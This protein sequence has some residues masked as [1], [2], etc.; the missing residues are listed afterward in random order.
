M[1]TGKSNLTYPQNISW[2]VACRLAARNIEARRGESAASSAYA[3]THVALLWSCQA[4]NPP[5]RGRARVKPLAK[6]RLATRAA[7][8][9]FGQLQ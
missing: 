2:P 9:S 7:V 6:N 4:S 1:S 8:T 3:N 5:L